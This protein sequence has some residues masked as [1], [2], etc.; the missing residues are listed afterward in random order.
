M[1]FR[2]SLATERVNH[3]GE[4]VAVVIGETLAAAQDGAEAVVGEL[5]RAR[6]AWS[7]PKPPSRK[8]HRRCI[9]TRQATSRS[10]GPASS[11]ANAREVERVFASAKYV[12]KVSLFHNRLNVASMEPRGATAS[13]DA[14]GRPVQPAG[15]ARRARAPCADSMAGRAQDRQRQDP[16]HHRRGRRRVRPQDRAVSPSTWA[17]SLAAAKKI[18]RPV[19]WMV[20]PLGE[21]SSPHQPRPRR[22]TATVELAL[23][24]KGKIPRPCASRHIGQHGR[25]EHRRRSAPTSKTINMRCAACPACTHIQADRRAD[26]SPCSPTRSVTAPLSRRRTPGGELIGIERVVDEA[27]RD[28]RHRPDQAAQ[29]QPHLARKAMPYK[30]AVGDHLRFRR[31]RRGD[32]PR[33]WAPPAALRGLARH[34]RKS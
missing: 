11:E 16:R 1:P 4:A 5:R 17:R 22:L 2:P 7:T 20:R 27:A 18:G 24:E 30:T 8:T 25:L 6:A 34:A 33:V 14:A 9:P 23:D 26:P 32:R 31:L 19:Y 29:A 28:H 10:I 12:A 15:L 3:I 13:Y 21:P